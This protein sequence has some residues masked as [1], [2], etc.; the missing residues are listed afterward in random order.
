MKIGFWE[1]SW[2]S[3]LEF[4][5]PV[6]DLIGAMDSEEDNVQV[7]KASLGLDLC[8]EASEKDG[9]TPFPTESAA[10]YGGLGDEEVFRK[11]DS[12]CGE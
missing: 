3:R 7:T 8:I 11:I 12:E 1:F 6:W 4:S 10:A 2:T 9:N 5:W